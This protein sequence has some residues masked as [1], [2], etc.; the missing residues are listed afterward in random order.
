V[1]TLLARLDEARALAVDI[2]SFGFVNL[3]QARHRL[4]Q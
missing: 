3:M 4:L 2:A 1:K